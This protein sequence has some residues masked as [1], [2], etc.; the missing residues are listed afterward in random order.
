[1]RFSNYRKTI[2]IS[3]ST[4]GRYKLM[5]GSEPSLHVKTL[6]LALLFFIATLFVPSSVANAEQPL[7]EQTITQ[8]SAPPDLLVTTTP[9]LDGF[10]VKQYKGLVKATIVRQ[11]TVGQGLSAT[12]ERL[13]GGKISAYMNMCETA[14]EQAFQLCLQRA[15]AM[16]ANAIIGLQ[17]DSISITH[18]DNVAAEATCYGTA[19]VIEPISH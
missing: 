14:R 7:A 4:Y 1:M 5:K 9:S 6:L 15:K 10:R 19:V 17:Y 8:S 12:V 3:Y 2:A 13:A 11:P 16:G 18:S